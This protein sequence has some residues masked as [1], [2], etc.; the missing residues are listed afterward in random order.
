MQVITYI[1]ASLASALFLF[2]LFRFF[3]NYSFK[4][5]GEVLASEELF[6]L[7]SNSKIILICV[8]MAVISRLISIAAAGIAKP[9]LDEA[10]WMRWDANHYV[11][12]AKNG[13]V[14]SGDDTVLIAFFP[15][16]PAILGIFGRIFSE[17]YITGSVISFACFVFAGF[18]LYKLARID[19]G[20]KAAFRTLKYF[21]LFPT[22]F[23]ATIPYTEGMFLL[24]TAAALYCIRKHKFW[25]AGVLGI[26]AA[27]CR[28]VGV[29]IALPLILEIA[30]SIYVDKFDKKFWLTLIKKC[31]PAII[32]PIGTLLYLLI[33][34]MVLGNPLAFMQI[35]K[36][37]WNQ[38]FGTL[39]NTVKYI[40]ENAFS[41]S[42]SSSA[43]LWT[44]QLISIFLFLGL[45]HLTI[46][47]NRPSIT[48]YAGV[49]FYF[50]SSLTWLLSAP[51]YLLAI[52][53]CFVAIGARTKN[54]YVDWALTVIFAIALFIFAYGYASGKDIY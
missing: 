35:Q 23:F 25:L 26:L 6:T 36:E 19:H 28:S 42:P 40:T 5:K 13:Y 41:W 50:S 38:G 48:A 51:R 11:T 3:K 7:S 14:S 34:L 24:I 16:Y 33:N 18:F 46:R 44:P 31:G 4:A 2:F 29:L 45:L 21:M 37:H 8:V 27:T 1:T 9:P 30:N 20:E 47:K 12:I 43:W 52:L 15:L 10:T 54:K 32:V 22:A 17:Y 39:F 49:L 53:P